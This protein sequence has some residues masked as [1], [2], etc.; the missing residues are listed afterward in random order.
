MIPLCVEES[1]IYIYIY[2]SFTNSKFQQRDDAQVIMLC[3]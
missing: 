3:L 2:I 1:D